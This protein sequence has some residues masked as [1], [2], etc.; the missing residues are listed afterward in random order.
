VYQRGTSKADLDQTPPQS[1]VIVTEGPHA[2]QTLL[3]IFKIE[4][5]VMIACI[6]PPGVPRPTDFTSQ[7]GS[8]RTL[9]VWL[10]VRPEDVPATPAIGWPFWLSVLFLLYLLRNPGNMKKDLEPALG[11]WGTLTVTGLIGAAMVLVICLVQKW[12]WRAGLALGLSMSV[13]VNTFEELRK[14]LEPTLGSPGAITVSGSTAAVA[15][16]VVGVVMT[17]LF[18][19]NW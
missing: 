11:Y 5:D 16:L 8:N 9:S 4:G 14:T 3:Q 1:D 7:P 10:R 6:A 17:R 19:L 18:R 2:G 15:G 13:A 12:G